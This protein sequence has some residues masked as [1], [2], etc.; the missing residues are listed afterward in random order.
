MTP[1]TRQGGQEMKKRTSSIWMAIT[2]VAGAATFLSLSGRT[3][4]GRWGETPF[5]PLRVGRRTRRPLVCSN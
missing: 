2:L 3:L 4:D 5:W 1:H